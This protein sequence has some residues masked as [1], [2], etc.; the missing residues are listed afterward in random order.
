MCFFQ[1]AIIL[2]NKLRF[3][4]KF[5][6]IM[7]ITAVAGGV[8]IFSLFKQLNEQIEFN[9]FETLGIDYLEP[10]QLVFEDAIAYRAVFA[11]GDATLEQ[12][13]E[14]HFEEVYAVDAQL[15][16]ILNTTESSISDKITEIEAAW[17]QVKVSKEQGDYEQWIASIVSIYQQEIANNSNLILDPDL[18]TYY[19]MNSYL[20]LI[21]NFTQSLNELQLKMDHYKGRILSMQQKIELVAL[22]EQL[23]QIVSS[24][25]S[26]FITQVK[27]TEDRAIFVQMGQQL[28]ELATHSNRLLGQIERRLIFQAGQIDAEM[29]RETESIVY[30]LQQG[31]HA[32]HLAH[33]ATL[34]Q[35]IAI[36]IADY[37]QVKYVSLSAMS[38]MG[39]LAFYF[40]I[41][42]Y[43][44]IRSAVRHL[45]E[46]A[47]R[48]ERGELTASAHLT[49]KDEFAVVAQSFNHII[50]SFHN[51]ITA[52][53]QTV[54]Q[55]STNSQ[56][57][58]YHAGETSAVTH[59]VTENIELFSTGMQQQ[60]LATNDSAMAVDEIVE[61]IEEIASTTSAVS[62]ASLENTTISRGGHAL[63]Q[64][65]IGQIS[66]IQQTFDH[67]STT[68]QALGERSQHINQIVRTM[69]EISE[70]T[71]LL[72]LNASIEAARA[73]D[74]GKGFAVVAQ[75]VRKLAELSSKSATQI[76]GL[77]YEVLEDTTMAVAAMEQGAKEV[78]Q[79]MKVVHLAGNAFEEIL[80]SANNVTVQTTTIHESAQHLS[81]ASRMI[82][83]KVTEMQA[84]T[85][86]SNEKTAELFHFAQQQLLA[87]QAITST[88]EQLNKIAK[89]LEGDIA[90][91]TV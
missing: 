28:E 60:L 57:L 23:E 87:M 39:L 78:D 86:Q 74:H 41:G 75:E 27:H 14:A 72:A 18:D 49:S 50:Q 46:V 45:Q 11:T 56:Q 62:D 8:L 88:S 82:T 35:L 21:P 90:H 47:Q 52:N 7:A 83:Q 32:Y 13:I 80:A 81:N 59:Q 54:Q 65:V 25:D 20:F 71:N 24:M 22:Y 37:K 84:I 40:I 26:N 66:A 36:R 16:P 69:E 48:V 9:T 63:L 2:L 73:G 12:A 5:F 79:G 77:I 34:D 31:A 42:F 29:L 58:L 33:A 51:I 91:F 44:S 68:I 53:H 61:R 1:P 85:T 17:Q 55:L 43:L 76:R 38:V 6:I 10:L 64:Q 89:Q 3:S 19:L 67:A 70:Q 4:M 30:D 15:G